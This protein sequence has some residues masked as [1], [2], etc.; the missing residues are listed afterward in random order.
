MNTEASTR[1][2]F[3]PYKISSYK[4]LFAAALPLM[5]SYLANTM[6]L[7]ADRM[8]LAQYSLS[9]MNAAAIVGT[10]VFL[11][12]YFF[13]NIAI[14][15]EVLIGR[16]NGAQQNSQ[17]A[18]PTWQMIWMTFATIPLLIFLANTMG[19]YFIPKEYYSIGE[20]Y[21]KILLYFAF[22]YIFIITMNAF[23]VGI[24]KTKVIIVSTIVGNILNIVLDFLLIFGYGDIIPE[25][26]IKG[27]AIASNIG[28]GAQAL[29]IAF[30]FLQ[31]KYRQKY[32]THVPRWCFKTLKNCL[33]L[34]LPTSI[35]ITLELSAWCFML[36]FLPSISNLHITVF[37]IGHTI[38]IFVTFISDGL[39]KALVSIISN[40][41]GAKKEQYS[42]K[43]IKTAF[44]SYTLISIAI[45]IVGIIFSVPIMDFFIANNADFELTQTLYK[46]SK[47]IMMCIAM[48]FVIEG[49]SWIFSGYLAAKERVIF[50]MF[51][52]AAS[53]WTTSA[54]PM[55][56]AFKY[57]H[58]NYLWVWALFSCYA[59]TSSIIFLLKIKSL[60]TRS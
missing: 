42:I 12:H 41:I 7:L 22:L 17:V 18:L 49:Y 3:T 38:F 9:A 44:I 30:V 36:Y 35:G 28:L 59:F 20:S 48:F 10:I 52:S 11:I 13:A 58:L 1:H 57:Y 4:E 23:F 14:L 8:I 6:M 24:G 46:N 29:I 27:A 31:K 56:I 47:L 39:K 50:I 45:S 25:L 26:G 54:I 21:Y 16:A 5:L 19:I 53:A 34:G 43:I 55:Y 40:C 37:T 51:V 33:K 2:S 32:M 60:L 15:S